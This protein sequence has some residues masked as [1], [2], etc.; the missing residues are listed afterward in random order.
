[1]SGEVPQVGEVYIDPD[2]F[3]FTPVPGGAMPAPAAKVSWELYN[4]KLQ[5]DGRT[6]TGDLDVVIFA[7]RP[8]CV[9]AGYKLIWQYDRATEFVV[10]DFAAVIEKPVPKP[11]PASVTDTIKGLV[12]GRK[13]RI[14][15]YVRYEDAGF[16]SVF[17]PPVSTS[18]MPLTDNIPG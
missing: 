10:S 1:M 9:F 8:G 3:K 7:S 16:K 5:P 17:D 6:K 12:V 4:V 18:L 14:G 11:P 13:L 2:P 15:V